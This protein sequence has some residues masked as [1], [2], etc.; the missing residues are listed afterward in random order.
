MDDLDD[1]AAA[2]RQQS[3][4]PDPSLKQIAH[5]VSVIKGWVVL[6]GM[7]VLLS[8]AGPIL[9]AILMYVRR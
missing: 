2:T 1:L 7:L 5:D 4:T 9:Y 6:F 3:K 8:I